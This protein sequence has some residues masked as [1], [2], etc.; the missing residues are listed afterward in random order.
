[1]RELTGRNDGVAVERY[2]AVTGLGKGYAWCAA[3]PSWVFNEAGVNAIK[4]AWSP[5]WFPPGNT[6]YHKGKANSIT[7][8]KADV[9]GIYYPKLKRIGH[10]GFV[11]NWQID[12]DYFVSVEGNTNN[13]GSREGDG[14]YRKRRLKSNVHKVSRWIPHTGDG[15]LVYLSR[16]NIRR[17]A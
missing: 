4:S 1:V 11:D 17:A 8:D 3:F 10:V 7:P 15:R 14:V 2:L 6:I 16:H 12:S 5:S 13:A 9:F